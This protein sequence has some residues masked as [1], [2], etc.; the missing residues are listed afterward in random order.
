MIVAVLSLRPLHPRRCF[1]SRACDG[2]VL[3]C[4]Y[5]GLA[6][7]S[8][9]PLHIQRFPSPYMFIAVISD[10]VISRILH[11][12]ARTYLDIAKTAYWL[13]RRVRKSD[14]AHAKS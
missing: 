4:C 5:T 13:K 7:H 6:F 1:R 14:M 2:A 10:V 12:L 3:N 9:H 8:S 11:W